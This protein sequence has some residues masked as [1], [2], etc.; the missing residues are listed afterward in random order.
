MG[1]RVHY[2]VMSPSTKEQSMTSLVTKLR[3]LASE[4]DQAQRALLDVRGAK[5]VDAGH[6]R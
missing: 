4:L 3:N 6:R 2:E 1:R 5:P